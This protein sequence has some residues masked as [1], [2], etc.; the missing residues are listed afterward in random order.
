MSMTDG[1]C[2]VTG[3]NTRIRS[4]AGTDFDQVGSLATG[5]TA[6]VTGQTTDANGFTWYQISQ[7]FVRG[8]VV[9]LTGNCMSV[10]MMGM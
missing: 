6:E 10:P 1:A 7:G 9:T 3:R 4:G 8:D 2:T 5:D